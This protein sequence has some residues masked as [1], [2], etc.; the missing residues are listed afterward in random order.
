[1]RT[2]DADGNLD[3]VTSHGTWYENRLSVGE[4]N[5]A[6][7]RLFNQRDDITLAD[8][9]GDGDLNIVSVHSRYI[10]PYSLAVGGNSLV[11]M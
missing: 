10:A 2:L 6:E 11:R 9:D 1:M 4:G 8:I 5:W 7:A 3:V